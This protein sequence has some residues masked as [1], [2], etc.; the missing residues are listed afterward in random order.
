MSKARASSETCSDLPVAEL[1]PRIACAPALLEQAHAALDGNPTAARKLRFTLA[2]FDGATIPT[3]IGVWALTTDI[4]A[5]KLS[6]RKR[7]RLSKAQSSLP[8]LVS[9]E[10]LE[11]V[12]AA[13]V[14]VSRTRRELAT[15]LGGLRLA[16]QGLDEMQHLFVLALNCGGGDQFATAFDTAVHALSFEPGGLPMSYPPLGGAPW[17]DWPPQS[18]LPGEFPTPGLGS[19][20]LPTEIPRLTRLTDYFERCLTNNLIPEMHRRGIGFVDLI[21]N[22]SGAY[23]IT[24]ITPEAVCPRTR[25]TID[26]NNFNGAAEV[27]FVDAS[28]GT[29]S[30]VPVSV[31]DSQIVVEVPLDA[32]SGPIWIHVPISMTLCLTT[33]TMTRPGTPGEIEIGAPVI[34]HFGPQSGLD[35]IAMFSSVDLSWVVSPADVEVTVFIVD[36]I[37]NRREVET[38]GPAR[39][40]FVFL[41]DQVGPW[42]FEIFANHSTLPCGVEAQSRT[43]NVALREHANFTIAAI[44][45]TQAIQVF[46][47]EDSPPEPNNAI[48]LTAGMDTVLRVY[49]RA[50]P[51]PTGPSVARC[52]GTV[53]MN[54]NTYFPMNDDERLAVNSFIIASEEPSRDNTNDSLNFLIP[55]AD[56]MGAA[57]EA[58]VEIFNTQT[59]RTITRAQTEILTWLDRPVLPVTIRRIAESGADPVD[60]AGPDRAVIPAEALRL[61]R[62]AFRMLPSPRTNIVFHPGVFQLN[63]ATAEDNYCREGGHYQLALSVA[64]EHNDNEGYPPTGHHT[65][66]WLGLFMG[67]GCGV[68]GM[69]AWPATSTC[70]SERNRVTIAHE[71]LHTIGLGHTKTTAGEDCEAVFQ[72]VACHFIRDA[73]GNDTNG[74][75]LHVGFDIDGN[76]AIPVAADIQSYRTDVRLW[77]SAQHY[78]LARDL[79]DTRY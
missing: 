43:L 67:T 76:S 10:A 56:A 26:G 68:P 78:L 20:P 70:I 42:T 40:N 63:A 2:K 41:P 77:T 71:L 66:S 64:A 60:G 51:S 16:L 14:Y 13:T 17:F 38:A 33:L 6:K 54:G 50:H 28:G 73:D 18:G 79:L 37:G 49:L 53:T 5:I 30:A 22:R 44:E 19:Q 69:M 9:F 45:H 59:C 74:T 29:V 57:N 23:Q 52:T 25:I 27:R 7:M 48:P 75:L 12:L 55:A 65:R 46:S 35:C 72:P 61:V 11:T 36:P 32:R 39:G 58:V 62:D 34:H 3:A 24:D 21:T 31:T 1:R 4:G 8:L 15:Y 47:L